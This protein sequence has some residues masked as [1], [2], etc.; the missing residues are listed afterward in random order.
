VLAK[1]MVEYDR[2]F[3]VDSLSA[4]LTIKIMADHALKMR[5]DGKSS[6]EIVAAVESLKSK[7]KVV[8]ALDT[9]EYLARG[10]RINKSVATI[11]N[12]AGIKPVIT[13]NTE[14]EVA[15]LGKCLGKNKAASHMLKDL[16][17]IG[18]DTDYP[19]Y[20]IYSYGTA[21]L[22][23]FR[24]KLAKANYTVTDCL[25]IGPVIGAH[26]GPEAFGVIFVGK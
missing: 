3:L 15:V 16:E 26:I 11:G 8:A 5:E 14:G 23:K 1:N 6:E 21:N 13:I 18:V 20:T 2:I 19:F 7:V 24:E 9:L 10:G 22:E 25:Q 4:T 12:L 17:A